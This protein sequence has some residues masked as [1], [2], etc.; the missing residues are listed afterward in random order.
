MNLN[1]FGTTV[2]EIKYPAS[3]PLS[4]TMFFWLSDAFVLL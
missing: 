4:E 1:G 3:T 2:L